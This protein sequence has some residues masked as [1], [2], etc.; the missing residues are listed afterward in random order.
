MTR[1]QTL[2]AVLEGT[3]GYSLAQLNA[4]YAVKG[5]DTF[6][7]FVESRG[8]SHTELA[9]RLRDFKANGGSGL[10]NAITQLTNELNAPTAPTDPCADMR[11][12]V[13]AAANALIKAVS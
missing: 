1:R 2:V 9:T 4:M 11:E 6:L 8:I 7:G 3:N 10:A 5:V 13:L 12:A